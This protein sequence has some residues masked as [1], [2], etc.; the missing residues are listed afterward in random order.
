MAIGITQNGFQTRADM[1]ESRVPYNEDSICI[2]ED[3]TGRRLTSQ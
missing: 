1:T 2:T 3:N